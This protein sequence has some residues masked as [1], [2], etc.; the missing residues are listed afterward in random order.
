[1]IRH[2]R[3][4]LSFVT[5][6][7]LSSI[8]F[9]ADE[10]NI[11]KAF[12]KKPRPGVDVTAGFATIKTNTDLKVMNVSNKNFKFY[13]NPLNQTYLNIN[14]N[15]NNTL[16]LFDLSGKLIKT[17]DLKSGNNSL[18]LEFLNK[19]LYMIECNSKTYT[20]AKI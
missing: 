10:I 12:I 17:F 11:S 2:L 9:G 7:L 14:L 6:I 16:S 13:P 3:M 1:M 19:G 18:N 5:L 4:K 20:I 8:V 15:T